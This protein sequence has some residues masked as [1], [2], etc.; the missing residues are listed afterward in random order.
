MTVTVREKVKER[1]NND[2]EQL[3]QNWEGY[4]LLKFANK[5]RPIKQDTIRR[6]ELDDLLDRNGIDGFE[7]LQKL[8]SDNAFTT[9]K[10]EGVFK[11]LAEFQD[12]PTFVCF[13]N[14]L[15]FCR[16]SEPRRPLD[17]FEGNEK[18]SVEVDGKRKVV[19]LDYAIDNFKK[20]AK[21]VEEKLKRESSQ[22]CTEQPSS[23][24]PQLTIPQPKEHN[25]NYYANTVIKTVIGRDEQKARLNAF[26]KCDLT[27]AWFQL[28]GV[29]GQGKSRLAFDLMRDASKKWGWRAGFLKENDI[30]SFK[31]HW[32]DWQPN[33]PHL[34]I[35]D[36]VVGREQEIKPILQ[37]LV[38][39]QGKFHHNIRILLVE[40]QRWD[41]G[42]PLK[43]QDQIDRDELKLSIHFRD[44]AQWFLKLCEEG[45]FEGESLKSSRFENGVEELEKL[46]GDKLVAIVKQLFSGKELTISDVALKKTL[47]RIDKSGCP[48][49]AYFF[50]QQLNDSQEGFQS[51]TK[52][53]LLDYQLIRNKRRWEQAFKNENP[54]WKS[55]VPTFGDHHPAMKLAV[56]ATM[57]RKVRFQDDP[58]KQYFGN[59]DSPLGKKSVAITSGYLINNDNRP[60]EIYGLEP[61]LLGE[62]F[63]LY[64]F[65]QGLEFEELLDISWQYS[66][67][68]MAEFLQRIT[69][70][71]IDPSK[72]YNN[73]DLIEKLLAYKSPQENHY[74]DL[75]SVAVVIAI[76]LYLRNLTIPQNIIVALEY[77]ANDFFDTISM[78]FLGFIYTQGIGVAKNPK[79]GIDWF[80]R[81]INQGNSNAMLKLGDY[82]RVEQN[83]DEAIRLYQQAVKLGNSNAMV[84]LGAI[85]QRGEGAKQNRVEAIRHAMVNLGVS[86]QRGEGVRQ[87]WDEAVRLYQQAVELGNSKAMFRL[88]HIYFQYSIG[89]L[90]Y[91]NQAA[92]LYRCAFKAGEKKAIDYIRTLLFYNFMGASNYKKTW[93]VNGWS[94]KNLPHLTSVPTFDPP[95]MAGNWKQLTDKEITTY[96]DKVIAPFEILGFA[97]MLDG[98]LGQYARILP[99]NF[100]KGCHLADIQL[101]NPSNMSTLIF[102]AVFNTDNAILLTGECNI[103][104]K[105]NSN[106]L[107]FD[108]EKSTIEYLLFF[109]S[110]VQDDHGPFQIISNLNEIP[111][112]KEEDQHLRDE[113]KTSFFSPRYVEGCFE[114]EGWQKFEACV[115]YGEYFYISTYKVFPNGMISMEDATPILD[116]LPILRRQYHGVFR[117][118]LRSFSR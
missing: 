106:L 111:F 90:Q 17:V 3:R 63:V 18:L 22:N 21:A 105:L 118:P 23:I 66:P 34:L 75:A 35:F 83:W 113:I 78:T 84:N 112:D 98:Y 93:K 38:F 74:Q 59:I 45:D 42:S 89:G 11:S 56:L 28:A 94:D 82:Y 27:V 91:W 67:D 41:Q 95:I 69:Q 72:Q 6:K 104:S 9:D 80:Q 33:K 7:T 36:Y 16:D 85:Y 54:N 96:L 116:K 114:R 8:P 73:W 2:Q 117:T 10:S 55:E 81:A 25:D 102:S 53:D 107:A 108:R 62:W 15:E 14:F 115:L 37:T 76:N 92:N 44:K 110:Y 13:I 19:T 109:N 97:E 4:H 5:I 24:Q 52:T 48:L 64:C 40:R 57:V 31:D 68:K 43:I 61:D 103:I 86:S 101:Y 87:N 51:W 32:K 50:A 58:I 100:Y 99:L 46:D 12:I 20:H 88:G 65:N 60:E 1:L 79:K 39:N 30:K 47:K 26:L 29:A 49:Y 71:F 70:D 77:A